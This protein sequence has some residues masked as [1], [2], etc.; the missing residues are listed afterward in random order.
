MTLDTRGIRDAL[1]THGKKLGVFDVVL[2][3]EPK[4]KPGA[5]TALALFSGELMPVES[6]G[7]SSTSML[8][9]WYGRISIPMMRE[10][11]DDIDADLL[12]A[13]AA[14]IGSLTGGFTLGGLVRAVDVFGAHGSPLGGEPGFLDHDGTKYRV[15][16]ITIPLIVNDVF[17][18]GA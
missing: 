2:A 14:F 7:L 1:I 5:G 12:S 17:D 10:P 11:Q 13:A 3:H 9:V 6:S 15:F 16:V 4:S 8:W 18:Q